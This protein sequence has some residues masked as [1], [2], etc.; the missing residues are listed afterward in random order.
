MGG[1][2][3]WW[4][5]DRTWSLGPCRSQP[6][7]ERCQL[8]LTRER[9]LPQIYGQTIYHRQVRPLLTEDRIT[10]ILHSMHQPQPVTHS[11][12]PAKA[13]TRKERNKS[14]YETK[15]DVIQVA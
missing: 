10:S 8:L 11:F 6:G 4:V 1:L 2:G 13:R 3:W 12:R 5:V 14:P 7:P 9:S 15:W